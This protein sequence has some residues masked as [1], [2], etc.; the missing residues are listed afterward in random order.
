MEIEDAAR[1]M[2]MKPSQIAEVYEVEDGTLVVSVGD[3]AQTL[4]ADGRCSA[5]FPRRELPGVRVTEVVA[6][7][8][9]AA[10]ASEPDCGTCGGTGAVEEGEMCP[11]CAEPN[12]DDTDTVPD[13]TAEKVLEWAGDDK[14]RLERALDAELHRESPRSTLVTKLSNALARIGAGS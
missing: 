5:V 4:I 12:Q 8:Q 6:E 9:E 13:A 11:D 10:A 1:L 7:E 14:A 3:G 2:G